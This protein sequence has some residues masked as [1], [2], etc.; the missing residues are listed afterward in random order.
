MPN[1]DNGK[2]AELISSQL[3]DVDTT[4][5]AAV[6]QTWQAVL[7][8]DPVGTVRRHADGRIAHRVSTDGIFLW[9][10][11]APDGD[12]YNDMQPTLDWDAIF[13]PEVEQ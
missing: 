8:G 9:R 4:Q 13:T 2:L 1:N 5:V 3:P 11:T 12:Q 7:D 6:L 10:V